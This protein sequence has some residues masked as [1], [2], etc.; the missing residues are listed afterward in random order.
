MP[1]K[2]RRERE[3]RMKRAPKLGTKKVFIPVIG[4]TSTIGDLRVSV[5]MPVTPWDKEES[6]DKLFDSHREH[7]R[8]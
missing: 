7:R 8:A 5:T 4:M 1:S 6:N 2:A 3:A